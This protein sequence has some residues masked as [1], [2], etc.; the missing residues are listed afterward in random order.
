MLCHLVIGGPRAHPSVD[1]TV[2]CHFLVHNIV[3]YKNGISQAIE[4]CSVP[5][6][7]IL[8]PK[9]KPKGVFTLM[10]FLYQLEDVLPIITQQ[11]FYKE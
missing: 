1:N 2:S 7:K 10:P 9:R 8:T 6:R 11:F 4:T 5:S 3:T